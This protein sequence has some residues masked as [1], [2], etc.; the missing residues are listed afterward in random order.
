M[1]AWWEIVTLVAG[2]TGE[3]E[4]EA[5]VAAPSTFDG[6]DTTHGTFIDLK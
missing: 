1:V 6:E 2:V 5:T 3:E 4:K